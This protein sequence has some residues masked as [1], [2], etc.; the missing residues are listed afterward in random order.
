MDYEDYYLNSLK[1]IMTLRRQLRAEQVK[2]TL[3]KLAKVNPKPLY[4]MNLEDRLQLELKT[5]NRGERIDTL[6]ELIQDY[7]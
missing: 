7:I 5:H 2:N 6:V 3:A 4:L 1:E